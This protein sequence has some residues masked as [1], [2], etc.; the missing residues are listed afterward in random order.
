M[1]TRS[2][3]PLSFLLGFILSR[4]EKHPDN[5]PPFVRKCA[6]MEQFHISHSFPLH[7]VKLLYLT[8]FLPDLLDSEKPFSFSNNRYI[9]SSSETFQPPS[10]SLK[11]GPFRER[12]RFLSSPLLLISPVFNV[13]NHEDSFESPSLILSLVIPILC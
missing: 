7:H 12:V 11:K 9:S 5:L 4:I 1:E 8:P 10:K 6:M 2:N 3:L 13:H